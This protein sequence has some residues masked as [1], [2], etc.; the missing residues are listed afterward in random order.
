M[1]LPNEPDDNPYRAQTTLNTDKAW[2]DTGTEQLDLDLDGMNDFAINMAT[3]HDNLQGRTGHLNLLDRLR[4]QAWQPGA[5]PEAQYLKARLQQNT[6]EF[7]QF[8]LNLAMACNNMGMAAQTIAYAFQGTDGWSA[9]TLDAVNF[10]YGD[11]SVGVPPGFPGQL[12]TKTWSEQM[13]ENAAN[14]VPTTSGEI[15]QWTDRATVT[16]ATGT[17][18]TAINQEGMVRTM[19]VFTVPGSGVTITTTTVTNPQG[20]V[21]STTSKRAYTYL[22]KDN[23]VVRVTTDYDAQGNETGSRKERTLYGPDGQP[24]EEST[25]SFNAKG[26]QTAS[27]STRTNDDGT[28]TITTTSGD[29]TRTV[30]IGEQTPGHMVPP[31]DPA[32]E[33]TRTLR[34]ST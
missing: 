21:V 25:A 9:A 5:L 31:T 11:R 1:A 30:H 14:G 12:G 18:H 20:K 4:E 2:L 32:M 29:Q 22:D 24:K 3:L 6:S 16:D 34:P 27:S 15:D 33:A 10:A 13:A 28:Q 26:E 17:H 7:R 19:T 8:F 23:A